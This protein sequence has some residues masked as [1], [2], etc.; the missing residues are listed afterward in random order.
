M[1]WPR[2]MFIMSDAF[3]HPVLSY[4]YSMDL[5]HFDLVAEPV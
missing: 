5:L 1:G 2:Y 4:I 3:S